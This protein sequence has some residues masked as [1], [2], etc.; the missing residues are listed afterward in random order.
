VDNAGASLVVLVLNRP[1]HDPDEQANAPVRSAVARLPRS[2]A[3]LPLYRLD[4]QTDLYLHDLESLRGPCPEAQGV[5]LARKAGCDLALAWIAS[6][7]IA[8]DWIHSTD[9]DATLPADYFD[10][11]AGASPGTV[12]ATF[13][14]RHVPGNDTACNAATALYELR[15][16]HYVLGL[17]YAGSPYAYHSLGSCLAIHAAAYA[18]VRGFPRRSGAEDFYLLGKVAKLGPLARPGGAPILIE[19]RKSSRVPFGT[20][21]AVADISG[22]GDPGM[23]PLFYHPDCYRALH[24]TLKILPGLRSSDA[25]LAHLLNREQLPQELISASV[26]AL[27]DMGLNDALEHC[28]R[29]G[30]TPAQFQRQFHQWFDAFRT[31]K[32][33]HAIRDSGRPAVSLAGLAELP[34]SLWPGNPDPGTDIETLRDAVAAHWG[35]EIP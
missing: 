7:A 15:L 35:W 27:Q 34:T 1:D 3:S 10:R 28:R 29:Q 23:Q 16:H 18:G 5:G 31:L 22:A 33:I 8:S 19:S 9:A 21:P 12:A 13:P 20:G 6:G 30:K 11:L 14:F 4:E 24:A 17:E 25:G 26:T 2:D 32:F